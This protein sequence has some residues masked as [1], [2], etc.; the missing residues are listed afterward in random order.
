M[1]CYVPVSMCPPD[2]VR[3]DGAQMHLQK[4]M[5][6]VS[7]CIYLISYP[8]PRPGSD[9]R[10]DKPTDRGAHRGPNRHA[11]VRSNRGSNRGANRGAHR[12]PD[13]HADRCANRGAHRG[14][15]GSRSS[16]RYGPPPEPR[17][18]P[19]PP[20]PSG[21]KKLLRARRAFRTRKGCFGPEGPTCLR[22]RRKHGFAQPWGAIESMRFLRPG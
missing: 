9:G 14:A 7:S 18:R 20:G 1:M 2:A 16:A 19:H 6:S 12:S 3:A 22:R 4:C 5:A 11:D 21:P 8:P 17:A 10:S 13:C 15:D